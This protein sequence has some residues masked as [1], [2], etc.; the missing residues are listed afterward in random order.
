MSTLRFLFALAWLATILSDLV[1]FRLVRETGATWPEAGPAI[2][3]GMVLGQATLL[4][5]WLCAGY[6]NIV[7]RLAFAISGV[8]G[9][10]LIAAPLTD[11]KI[12]LW[13]GALAILVLTTFI[14]SYFFTLFGIRICASGS[15]PAGGVATV[16]QNGGRYEA[17][18][19]ELERINRFTLWQLM[20]WVTAVALALGV[21]RQLPMSTQLST[22]A[23][24]FFGV[25]AIG[26]LAAIWIT[27]RLRTLQLI[28]AMIVVVFVAVAGLTILWYPMLG[29]SSLETQPIACMLAAEL[30]FVTVFVL[31]MK[32]GGLR[33]VRLTP[34]SNL[35]NAPSA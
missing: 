30:V 14:L 16:G 28:P 26:S 21:A 12:E 29:V 5:F 7:T 20:S 27:L 15:P 6:A 31:A 8:T 1:L 13:L 17:G 19:A 11:G 33:I 24:A 10:A 9:T 34:P 4:G 23:F 3:I 25:T 2:L 35:S 22:R 18:G 32:T